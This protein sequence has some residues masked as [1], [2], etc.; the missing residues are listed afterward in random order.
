MSQS[1]SKRQLEMARR[2][3]AARK[4]QRR[5]D[6]AATQPEVVEPVADET[7]TIAALTLLHESYDAGSIDFD[8][9]EARKLELI[10]QL[11]ID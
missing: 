3:R 11:R 7:A 6:R 9:F 4:R 8:E 1:S 5:E 10:A 2:E